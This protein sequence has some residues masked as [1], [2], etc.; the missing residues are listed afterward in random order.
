VGALAGVAV[1]VSRPSDF[2]FQNRWY[3]FSDLPQVDDDV[4]SFRSR[5]HTLAQSASLPLVMK[6]LCG[7]A[8]TRR[9]ILGAIEAELSGLDNGGLFIFVLEGHGTD[10]PD[11]DG[12]E[13][14]DYRYDQAFPTA[15]DPIID[16]DLWSLW[17]T[18]P[19]IS[20]FTVADTCRSETITVRLDVDLRLYRSLGAIVPAKA[21]AAARQAP[22]IRR[23]ATATGPSI[24]QYAAAVRGTDAED[25]LV[26]GRLGGRWTRA[27]L[28]A[29]KDLA[30][31]STYRTW[32]ETA[33][34]AMR[35]T[36]DQV[37]VLYYM[38][39]DADMIDRRPAFA[40]S[41]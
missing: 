4:A 3:R 22:V 38:G 12:D 23:L 2:E 11:L 19:D 20:I 39:P 10:V 27:V 8:A 31:L 28:D 9:A 6:S 41:V 14:F 7:P 21:L 1:G 25:A 24:L 17:Q 29:S 18:R 13:P 30:H 32:F 26:M 5:I 33:D 36:S 15:D 40:P 34:A 35:A 37:P 16:D